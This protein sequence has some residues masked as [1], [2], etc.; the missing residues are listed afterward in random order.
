MTEHQP[1]IAVGKPWADDNRNGYGVTSLILGII[2]SLAGLIPIAGM[3]VGGPLGVIG[4]VLGLAGRGRIKR[5]QA[6]NGKQTLWGVILSALSIVLGIIGLIIV[7]TA[8][9]DFSND[10]DQINTDLSNTVE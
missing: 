8:V 4:L 3:L 2:G 9:S 5:G 7:I 1:M 6:T 10:I